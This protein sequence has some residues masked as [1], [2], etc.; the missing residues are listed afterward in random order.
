MIRNRTGPFQN[1]FH[2]KV[3]CG[4]D[5]WFCGFVVLSLSEAK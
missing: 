2:R 4:F 3:M 1:S 5:V